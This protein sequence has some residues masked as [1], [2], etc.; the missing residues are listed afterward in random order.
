MEV[1]VTLIQRLISKSDLKK[2]CL[3]SVIGVEFLDIPGDMEWS[4][5]NTPEGREMARNPSIFKLGAMK[6]RSVQTEKLRC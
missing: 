5:A 6:A 3:I 2:I 1:N 4:L